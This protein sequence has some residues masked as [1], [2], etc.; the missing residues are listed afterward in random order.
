VFLRFSEFLEKEAPGYLERFGDRMPLRHKLVLEHLLSCRT[1]ALG[2]HLYACPGCGHKHFAY[3]SCND[4]HCPCC[5]RDE[6]MHW[7]E[8]NRERLG[9]GTDYFMITF[10]IPEPLRALFRRAQAPAYDA[11]F[12]SSS[13]TLQDLAGDPK[14][15]G[16]QLGMLAVMHTWTRTMQ[17]HPHIH[18]LVPAGALS[19]DGTQWLVCKNAKYLFPV[20]RL[21]KRYSHLLYEQLKEHL[22]QEHVKIPRSTWKKNWIVHCQHAGNGDKALAYLSN[23]VFK[24]ATADRLIEQLPDGR[25]IWPYVDSNT[26][27]VANITLHAHE[28]LRRF[29]QHIQPSGFHRVRY[30]GFIHPSARMRANKV[31]A[32]LGKAPVLTLEE[33]RVWLEQEHPFDEPVDVLE[34]KASNNAPLLCPVCGATLKL[35]AQWHQ[36]Q[37]LPKVGCLALV[38]SQTQIN[39]TS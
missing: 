36:G 6:G 12:S 9:L 8:R 5:G 38:Q 18:F 21:A 7:L 10:T 19:G 33:Q 24:T 13:R 30:Y 20:K 27:Q 22:P 34:N 39:D 26:R 23:Y 28:L 3:H 32:L 37:P 31:R 2:G 25:V 4:R 29:C 17:Y 16:G 11:L 35:I 1:P 15:L 14:Y